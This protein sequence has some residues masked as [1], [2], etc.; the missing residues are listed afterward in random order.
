VKSSAFDRWLLAAGG[1]IALLI[2]SAILNYRNTEALHHDGYWVAHT[3]EVLDA[4]EEVVGHLREA[5][6]VQRTYL[7]LG[8]DAV[9]PDF[10]ASIDSAR[11]KV[12]KVQGLTAD[13]GAQQARIPEIATRVEDLAAS[14]SGA[15]R[16]RR[17]EGF[18]AARK[19]VGAGHPGYVMLD[20]LGRLREMDDA[21]RN[22]LA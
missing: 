21:E 6:A 10:A 3:H 20:V 13:N 5:Q 7:I 17:E 1:L 11:Q 16:V 2:V 12:R 18:D 19:I 9:P 15:M 22:L 8:G 14:W 4:L